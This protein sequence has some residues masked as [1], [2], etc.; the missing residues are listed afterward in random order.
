MVQL[1]HLYMTTGKTT[2]LGVQIFVSKVMSLLFNM[3]SRPKLSTEELMLLN[4]GVGEDSWH[5]LNSK[6]IQP[7]HPKGNQSWVF[8]GR[9]DAKAETPILWPPD[10]KNWLISIDPDAGKDWRWEEQG[11]TEDEMVG[12][13]NW[14]DEQEFEK[15]PGV[16]DGQESLT[17][18]SPWGHKE[19]D[20]TEQLN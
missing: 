17:C 1:S 4:C 9:T 20:M 11:T 12:W 10:A 15:T 14:L 3:L 13:G 2:A 19:S 6:E 16:G 18:C 5:F 8:F 7:V